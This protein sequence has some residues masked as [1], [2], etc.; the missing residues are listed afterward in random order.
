M[1]AATVISASAEAPQRAIAGSPRLKVHRSLQPRT[2]V[3]AVQ[4]VPLLTVEAPENA[5]EVPFSCALGNK[6]T[7]TTKFTSVDADEDGKSWKIGGF[8]TYSACLSHDSSKE[9]NNDWIMS[10]AIH[11][12]PG[13]E[14]L[15]SMDVKG[16]STNEAKKGKYAA[17]FGSEPT[18]AAMTKELVATREVPGK[19]YTTISAKI[20]VTEEGYYYIGLQCLSTG[21]ISCA[22]N[23]KIEEYKAPVDAPAAGTVEY[24]V[25]PKGELVADVVYT[26]PTKTQSGAD[27]TAIQKIVVYSWAQNS[28]DWFTVENAEPGKQYILQVPLLQ[29]INNRII[30]I[31]YV[32]DT[33]GEKVET[34][35][36]WAG[37]DSPLDPAGVHAE[38]T[39]DY[40][41]VVLSW[42]PVPE[43]GENGG[44]VDP[45]TVKY[46]IF[47]AFGSIYDPAVAEDVTSP[48]TIDCSAETEQDFHAYQV[49]ALSYTGDREYYCAQQEG[50]S[51][52][53]VTGT[54]DPLPWHESFSDALYSHIWCNDLNNTGSQTMMSGTVYDNE[55]QTNADAEE[56]TEP[57]Y[58]NSH[59]ADNGFLYALPIQKDAVFGI[60]SVKVDIS[61]AT[62][63]VFEL[64]Y[65]G[66]GSQIEMLVGDAS[67]DLKTARTIDLS[68]E[69]KL[70]EWTLA[71]V[72]L[73]PYKAQKYVCIGYRMTAIHN[74]DDATF[75]VPVDNFR[76]IDLAEND[77]RVSYMSVPEEATAGRAA[78]GRLSVE[79]I[80]TA[81][82]AAPELTVLKDGEA[83]EAPEIGALAPGQVATVELAVPVS[84]LDASSI[85][86]SATAAAPG[87]TALANN[88]ATASVIVRQTALTPVEAV[89]ASQSDNTVTLT[90]QA[91]VF[92]DLTMAR[93]VTE[94]FE[95]PDYP[96]LT[97]SNFGGWT[98]VDGDK[99]YTYG[100]VHDSDNPYRGYPHA[101]QLFDPVKAGVPQDE[102]LDV[103]THS[104]NTML[105]AVSGKYLNDNWLISPELSGN[106]QTISFWAKSFTIAF[107]ESFTVYY[108]TKGTDVADFEQYV[109]VENYPDDGNLSE[110][111]TEYKA[112]LP[113]GAT[114]FAIVHDS[115][116][117]YMLMLDDITYETAALYPSDLALTGYNIYRDGQFL[118]KAEDA[119]HTDAPGATGKYNYR[120][121][122]LYNYGESAACPATEVT[123]EYDGA[124]S[125]AGATVTIGSEPGAIIVSGAE[126]K[127]LSVA[128]AD[129]RVIF[130]GAAAAVQRI[131][132]ATGI[133]LVSADGHIAK[134]V[135]R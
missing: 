108:S 20:T 43:T 44:Y 110:D 78:A 127:A 63:P 56:G 48:Y 2:A 132:A 64:F 16:N 22:A 65:K 129:G 8:S 113:E 89:E 24:T 111:W 54:P 45:S 52:I 130:S 58:L 38:I 128:S 70:D 33:A 75:S 39:E 77:L 131:P 109:T 133:Y 14:Y 101:Y 18:V 79:N 100:I 42:E 102:L 60:N 28:P 112:A 96:A 72:D 10:P 124:Q 9:H 98:M 97:I 134:V 71:R 105:I 17:F 49:T 90:W 51:N 103:P 125:V 36:F 114:H 122:A 118:A 92:P 7:N 29:G 23:F 121:S 119:A 80:G 19:N 83:I 74:T 82:V 6:D 107:P 85:A 59:D 115:Y 123:F 3:S 27:L 117:T 46:Y 55:L 12:L 61:Q 126:G 53:V 47:D 93:S 67:G 57:E 11:L 68:Q 32:E 66:T 40:G 26:A 104:G 73:T 69:G 21:T 4:Q 34:P 99:D 86:I 81:A 76:V 5:V 37:A 95:N 84:V 88:S 25:R 87:E 15:Y 50:F 120:V 135:V 1:L 116:D 35:S 13:K 31:A 94:D 30:G 41:K 91:P 62:H 106:A